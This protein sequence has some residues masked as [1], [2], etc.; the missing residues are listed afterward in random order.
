MLP[1]E[2]KVYP[3]TAELEVRWEVG[4]PVVEHL[5]GIVDHS[6]GAEVKSLT[7]TTGF[8]DAVVEQPE[9]MAE[10]RIRRLENALSDSSIISIPRQSNASSFPDRELDEADSRVSKSVPSILIE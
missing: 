1:R 7:L 2:G 3:L 10:L 9:V 4:L 6:S 5:E 8:E